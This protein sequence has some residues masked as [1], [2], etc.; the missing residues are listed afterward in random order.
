MPVTIRDLLTVDLFKDAEV[1]A[2]KSGLSNE[3]GRINFADCPMP[4]NI[5]EETL[6]GLVKKGD[7]FINSFYIIKDD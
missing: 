7:L 5:R 4:E 2:G 6:C 3:I 1:V